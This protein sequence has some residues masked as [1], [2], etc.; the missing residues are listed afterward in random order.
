MGRARGVKSEVVG[1]PP[2]RADRFGLRPI[3]L[4]TLRT[5][6][7]PSLAAFDRGLIAV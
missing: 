7:L 2:A 3:R 4:T 1:V 6:G 5:V